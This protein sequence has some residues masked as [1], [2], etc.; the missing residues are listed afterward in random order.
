MSKKR[1][2]G[3]CRLCNSEDWLVDSHIIPDFHFKPLK[4]AEGH[5][6]VQSTDP[7]RAVAKRQK[8]ITE[9]L[10]C[11]TCDNMRLSR[12]EDHLA[13][14]VFG[15]HP[16]RARESAPLFVVE[17]YDYKKVKN[18]L[19]SILWRMSLT[20]H[21]YFSE[22]DLG[23]K[24]EE[25]IRAALLSDTSFAEEEYP[26]LLTAPVFS[27]RHLADCILPTDFTRHDGNRVY[28]CY[29]SGLLFTFFVGS[30]ALGNDVR[31]LILRS[32]SWPIVRAK[33]EDI[34]FLFDACLRLGRAN[35][36]RGNM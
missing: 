23:E 22:E 12:Y 3:R 13:K 4:K 6:Y 20:K 11:A 14:V 26:I 1:I 2:H 25:R 31:R 8:G 5:F 24:H 16:L 36:L 10:F 29:I 27:G 35:A 32:A 33:V 7:S 28:R 30:A 21:D 19:L 34:P 17:G 15:G 9:N 18:G